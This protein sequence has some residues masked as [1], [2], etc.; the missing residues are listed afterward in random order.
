MLRTVLL[1]FFV[2]F[3]F[4][5]FLFNCFF[6]FF[7]FQ[8][9]HKYIHHA[10]NICFYSPTISPEGGS[11]I[12]F[13]KLKQLRRHLNSVRIAR[14]KSPMCVTIKIHASFLYVDNIHLLRCRRQFL[15]LLYMKGICIFRSFSYFFLL[16]TSF[17]YLRI[18]LI[19]FFYCTH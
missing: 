15:G 11:S 14:E 16:W 9:D 10:R 18:Y 12:V 19:C 13:W 6:F 8:R 3:L 1:S 5:S 7:L 2:C 4:P 17:L